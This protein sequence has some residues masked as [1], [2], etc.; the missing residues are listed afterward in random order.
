MKSIKLSSIILFLTL[1]IASQAWALIEYK[2][3]ISNSIE[4]FTR[5]HK[6]QGIFQL[7]KG[8]G[9]IVTQ[10]HG[11]A[12]F[13]RNQRFSI[14]D[15][16]PIMSATQQMTASGIL[17]LEE[18]GLL[19]VHDKVSKFLNDENQFWHGHK[20]PKWLD[21]VTLHHLLSHSSGIPKYR[22]KLSINNDS[23]IAQ[24]QNAMSKFLAKTELSFAPGSKYSFSNS[25]YV[26]LGKIIEQISKESLQSFFQKEFFD[27]IDMENSYFLSNTEALEIF[28]N[29]KLEKFSARYYLK[30][31]DGSLK[32]VQAKSEVIGLPYGDAGIVSTIGDLV[33]WNKALHRGKILSDASYKKLTSPY[34][35]IDDLRIEYKSYMGYGTFIST[36]DTGHKYYHHQSTALGISADTGYIP[37]KDI[38]LAILSNIMML[39]VPEGEKIDFREAKN[40]ID[41]P[42]LRNILLESL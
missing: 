22:G 10:A 9:N 18:R 23:S 31:T 26:L 39:K 15:P 38:S 7:D 17:L 6:I 19:S 33:K 14:Y 20:R 42:Y 34:F 16:M 24:A 27:K 28:Q 11:F 4:N 1:A 35:R 5:D 21:E 36:L 2:N 12:N 13:D 41:I 25:G 37:E 8:D 29:E 30:A 32:F 40:Q 3:T